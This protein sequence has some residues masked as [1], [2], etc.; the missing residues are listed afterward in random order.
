[1]KGTLR[2]N[3]RNM[4][5]FLKRKTHFEVIFHSLF[6]V[7]FRPAAMSMPQGASSLIHKI[8]STEQGSSFNSSA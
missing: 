2:E 4:A 3:V 5:G 7:F 8:C 1:M 6:S